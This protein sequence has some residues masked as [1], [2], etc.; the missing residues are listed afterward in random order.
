MKV[1]FNDGIMRRWENAVNIEQAES[2]RD[3][4][5]KKRPANP[6]E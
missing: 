5:N 1:N 3:E 4:K 2:K 6:F